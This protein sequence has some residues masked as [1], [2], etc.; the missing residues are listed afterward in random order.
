M[1]CAR[2][3]HIDSANSLKP[4]DV[5]ADVALGTVATI[6]VVVVAAAAA[7]AAAAAST[8]RPVLDV[9][10]CARGEVML[11]LILTGPW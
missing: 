9:T 5:V 1:E 2:W 4:Y 11:A 6:V 7:A 10:G 8:L 3:K